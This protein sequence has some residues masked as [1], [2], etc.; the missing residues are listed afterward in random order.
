M[1]SGACEGTVVVIGTSMASL[2]QLL[3]KRRNN[4]DIYMNPKPLKKIW[5]THFLPD[6]FL[7]F[8]SLITTVVQNNIL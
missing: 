8:I 5:T 2:Q 1:K 7:P 6:L 4:T 3:R